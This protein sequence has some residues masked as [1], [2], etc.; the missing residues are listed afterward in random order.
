MA[1][2]CRGKGIKVKMPEDVEITALENE[3]EI[4]S[5][6][7]SARR[8][9]IELYFRRGTA[10]YFSDNERS[11]QL[12]KKHAW[13]T[14]WLV[15]HFPWDP[16]LGSPAI[17]LPSWWAESDKAKIR[18]E[19][20]NQIESRP[21]HAETLINAARFF[22]FYRETQQDILHAL[23]LAE[24]AY[25]LAPSDIEARNALADMLV[26]RARNGASKEEAGKLN[27]RALRVREGTSKDVQSADYSDQLHNLAREAFNAGDFQKAQ[28]YAERLLELGDIPDYWA[29]DVSSHEANLILGRIALRRDDVQAAKRYLAAAGSP[30]LNSPSILPARGPGMALARELLEKGEVET[31]LQYLDA[32]ERTWPRSSPL[33]P[34]MQKLGEWREVVRRRGIPDFGINLVD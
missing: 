16:I 12:A 31:V 6:D 24:R 17:C 27:A 15:T 7:I 3:L 2:D 8:K 20:I 33:A 5:G 29:G 4:N 34:W 21:N 30:K 11:K 26:E 10:E 13:H 23:S 18:R 25:H 28:H 32:C 1:V 14:L 19:W 9:L 22:D